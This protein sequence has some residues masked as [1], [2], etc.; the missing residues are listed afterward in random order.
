MLNPNMMLSLVVVVLM[1]CR[2]YMRF[3][4]EDLFERAAKSLVM[5]VLPVIKTAAWMGP[6][7]EIM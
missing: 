1:L 4:Y 5:N 6:A 2:I 7:L 3:S